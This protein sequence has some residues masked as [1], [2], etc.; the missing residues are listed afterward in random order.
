MATIDV[1]L[2][3]YFADN[4]GVADASTAIN[5]AIVA[6]TT[7]QDELY[8]PAGTYLINVA[9]SHAKNLRFR[10][11]DPSP[12][13]GAP[14]VIWNTI[15]TGATQMMSITANVVNTFENINFQ[16]NTSPYLRYPINMTTS[17]GTCIFRRCTWNNLWTTAGV[18]GGNIIM[19][20]CEIYTFGSR[21]VVVSSLEVRN[22]KLV[23]GVTPATTSQG[24]ILTFPAGG[25][26]LTNCLI[27][28][29]GLRNNFS[30]SA[31]VC[32][33][34][35]CTLISENPLT[36]IGQNSA[37]N[38]S[39]GAGSDVLF[40]NCIIA[41]SP[42]YGI[43]NTAVTINGTVRTENCAFYNNASGGCHPSVRQYNSINLTQDPF[44]NAA[45]GD[46]RLNNNPLGG[47]LCKGAG[48]AIPGFTGDLP[49]I[50]AGWGRYAVGTSGT[51]I[52]MATDFL[53]HLFNNTS[54]PGIGDAI[55]L[56]GSSVAGSLYVGL[57][58][59]NPAGGNQTTNEMPTT[60]WT[61]YVRIAIA[62]T[63]TGWGV[64]STGAD[65]ALAGNAQTF[66]FPTVN[67]A[68]GT[69]YY[70]G[71]G[72][73]LTGAGRLLYSAPLTV[74]MVTSAGMIPQFDPYALSIYAA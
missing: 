21:P 27:I 67:A 1:T 22:S 16:T 49:D 35:R 42:G 12:I 5:N 50:G 66:Q 61:S 52:D 71:I 38:F 36:G 6:A 13:T 59:N 58:T 68:A 8:F 74:P 25:R 17:G 56:R 20:D 34:D 23:A 9:L 51:G 3:P 11:A 7:N 48:Y 14:V 37:Y 28:G 30:T 43:D 65:S 32:I 54:I 18:N 60:N 47:G 69:V 62:R 72:T 39:G 57:Y 2:S 24:I 33:F 55:G 41:N 19:D 15:L 31:G 53:L 63:T 73:S 64:V 70:W 26:G 40:R 29:A 45:G 4:T 44:V 46:Y 10:G